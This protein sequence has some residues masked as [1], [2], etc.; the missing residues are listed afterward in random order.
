MQRF[1]PGTRV[2][3][4]AAKTLN[5]FRDAA[6]AHEAN[7]GGSAGVDSGTDPSQLVVTG[8][9]P[10][11]VNNAFRGGV[12]AIEGHLF[13][14]ATDRQLSLEP[15]VLKLAEATEDD[16]RPK[17]VLLEKGTGGDL[18]R[19]AV[20]S[21][22][23]IDVDIKDLAD[24][25]CDFG[26]EANIGYLESGRGTHWIVHRALDNVP[27]LDLPSG[28]EDRLGKQECLVLV[29]PGGG[30]GDTGSENVSIGVVLEGA[31]RATDTGYPPGSTYRLTPKVGRALPLTWDA[32]NDRFHQSNEN[33]HQHSDGI[34]SGVLS[35]PVVA[36]PSNAWIASAKGVYV[37]AVD[38]LEEDDVGTT[39]SDEGIAIDERYLEIT[40]VTE[41]GGNYVLTLDDSG[42]SLPADADDERSVTCWIQPVEPDDFLWP[43]YYGGIGTGSIVKL[44]K[45][46][47]VPLKIAEPLDYFDTMRKQDNFK[48]GETQF[49][50]HAE[51][52][53]PPDTTGSGGGAGGC[54]GEDVVIS[55]ACVN[56]DVV[57]T[58]REL[59][60]SN[61]LAA[62]KD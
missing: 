11:G 1:I 52:I 15:I 24:K 37:P 2:P 9:V 44:T 20:P 39:G 28:Y 25:T 47:G 50:T 45:I 10:A 18:L 23:W 19:I 21:M 59:C 56:G 32:E 26:V 49:Y 34:S 36:D 42:Y 60:I 40:D 6:L 5:R 16:E 54:S 13:T 55:V 3:G 4:F 38:A 58:T 33:A 8:L 46:P 62:F 31:G 17:A 35:V 7:R 53:S 30:S 43:L 22:A 51:W 12:L 57:E 27:E 14:S 29:E 48:E 41:T 61:G